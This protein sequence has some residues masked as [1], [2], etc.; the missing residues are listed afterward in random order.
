MMG[1]GILIIH[2]T[3]IVLYPFIYLIPDNPVVLVLTSIIRFFFQYIIAVLF[4]GI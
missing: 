3:V 4:G 2:Y 1:V